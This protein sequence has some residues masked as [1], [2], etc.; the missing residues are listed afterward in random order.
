MI[1]L[2]TNFDDI[3]MYQPY[4]FPVPPRNSTLLTNVRWKKVIQ[5]KLSTASDIISREP[6][7]A[8]RGTTLRHLPNV[9]GYSTVFHNGSS[10][11]FIL[12]ESSSMPKLVKLEGNA[13][14]SLVPL[15]TG[16]CERGFISIDVLVSHQLACIKQISHHSREPLKAVNCSHGLV[17]ATL[18]GPQ[19]KSP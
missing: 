18:A 5:P 7:I 1:Q 19:D 16:D 3:V 8:G 11:A 13:I 10:P 12:K 2:R 15:H 6:T 9:G 14:S 4:H 17:M